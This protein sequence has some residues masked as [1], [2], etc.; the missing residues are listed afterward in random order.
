MRGSSAPI[1]AAAR[2]AAALRAVNSGSLPRGSRSESRAVALGDDQN[3]HR[4]ALSRV[5]GQHA[6][7]AQDFVIGMRRDDKY[8][9]HR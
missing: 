5:P 8:R 6:T 9:S 4:V 1:A 3:V 7:A 2:E